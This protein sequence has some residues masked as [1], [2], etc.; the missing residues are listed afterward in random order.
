MHET[1]R[2]RFAPI[3]GTEPSIRALFV[4]RW[5]T[6]FEEGTAPADLALDRVRFTAGAVDALF[7]AGQRGWRI[8]LVGNEDQVAR[9]KVA[10]A[11]WEAFE[12]ELLGR[13]ASMGVRIARSYACLDHP[14]GRGAHRKNSVFRFPDTGVFFHA[15]QVDGVDLDESWALGD[16]TLEL[17]AASRAGCRTVGLRTGLALS[18]RSLDVDLDLCC[19]TLAEAVGLFLASEAYACAP[20]ERR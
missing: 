5:G 13:L 7:Q 17:A 18:D 10:D 20:V 2:S 8:Y 9:G 14:E 12:R 11:A 1:T 15:A 16:G 19:D 3:P 4:D 6:L